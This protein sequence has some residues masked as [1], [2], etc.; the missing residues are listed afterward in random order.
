[1]ALGGYFYDRRKSTHD[2]GRTATQWRDVFRGQHGQVRSAHD[3]LVRDFNVKGVKDWNA[4]W[5]SD[6][7]Q[8]PLFGA[9]R[10]PGA[11]SIT[12]EET[13]GSWLRQARRAIV[14]S[15]RQPSAKKK[16]HD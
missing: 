13:V 16:G 10:Q 1:V 4:R 3:L 11:R 15:T 8:S 14:S 6:L 9:A 5:V 12:R 7:S 2:A